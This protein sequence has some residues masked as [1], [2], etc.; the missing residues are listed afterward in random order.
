MYYTLDG[1]NLAPYINMTDED[2]Y[3]FEKDMNV[4]NPTWASL[5]EFRKSQEEL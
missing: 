3:D 2:L 1:N 4:P 5:D